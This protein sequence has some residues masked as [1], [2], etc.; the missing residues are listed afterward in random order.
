MTRRSFLKT[1]GAIGGSVAVWQAMNAWDLTAQAALREPPE[2][3]G[4]VNGTSVVVLGAGPAGAAIAYEL[5]NL[6]YDVQVLEARDRIGGHVYTVRQG[7]EI[8]ELGGEPQTCEYD[9]GQYWNAG[10]WRIP[11]THHATL[12]Y[13]REFNIP[14]ER[15]TN[16]NAQAWVYLEDID[17]PLNGER[18]RIHTL[19][20]DMRGHTA[21][22][23]AKA[24]DG[25]QLDTD[26]SEEDRDLLIE[27]LVAEGLL[28]SDDLS[29][30]PNTRR[31]YMELPGAGD[32]P[33]EPSEPI[34]LVDLLPFGANGISSAGSYLASVAST[35]QQDSMFQPVGGMDQ[36]FVE[37]FA[38]EIG[39]AITYG[40]AVREIQQGDNQVTIVYEDLESGEEQEV[41][42][43]Y[44][45]STIPLSALIQIQT[46]FSSEMT[47]AIRGVPYFP[48]G[49]SGLQFS[50]RFW[51]EDDYIY[52]GMSFTNISEIGTFAYPN[53]GFQGEKGV[54]QAY[55]NFGS[56]AIEVS[57]LSNQERI[58]MALEQ[59]SK[60]H[61]QMQDTFENGMSIAWHRVP[62][63]LG[64][65]PDHSDR[66][67]EQY[68]P[69]LME[70]DGRVYLA[71]EFLSHITGWMEGA[72]QAAWVQFEKLHQRVMEENGSS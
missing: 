46:D 39:N 5:M 50:R 60:F 63:L 40:A 27:Y 36:I 55:Y 30:G 7:D 24:A 11:Q 52:G 70:P 62:F 43:D 4:E 68:L 6:G 25:G 57:N 12:H 14:L 32:Q 71:G 67:Y 56:T 42:A 16:V 8:H 10:A 3:D 45:V 20:A 59:G 54:V 66:T 21:E 65:W 15:H 72:F 18:L 53:Y 29:Y 17:G 22:L 69:T 2:V 1:L 9:E 33:G 37:G 38:S 58:E 26:L 31:G 61:P 44:C 35:F 28:S 19:Q 51:E 41:T 48:S 64:A 49:K 23:L 13:C 34:D 47:E